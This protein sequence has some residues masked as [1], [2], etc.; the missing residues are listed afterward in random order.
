[1]LAHVSQLTLYIADL[2]VKIAASVQQSLQVE[3]REHTGPKYA[4]QVFLN[5]TDVHCI[6]SD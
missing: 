5:T 2:D 1:M 3:C 6:T 4:Q